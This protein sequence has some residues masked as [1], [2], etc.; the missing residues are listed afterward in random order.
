[1]TARRWTG[2]LLGVSALFPPVL[3]LFPALAL[4]QAPS[5]RDQG[6]FFYPLKLYT[7]DRLR[8]REL[9]LWNPLSG[10]GEPWLANLQSGVFYP[11]GI[12]FLLPGPALAGGLFLLF[13]FAVA[14]WGMWRFLREE[15][16]SEAGAAVGA[17]LF[18]ASGFAASLSAYWNHFGAYAWLPAAVALARSGLHRRRDRVGLAAVIGLQAMAGSPEISGATLLL[19]LLFSWLSRPAADGGYEAPSPR[20]TARAGAA[21]LLGLALA[22][23]AL[24]PFAQ[25]AA[26]SDRRIPLPVAERDAGAVEWAGLA[27]AAGAGRKGSGTTYLPSLAFGPLALIAVAAALLE[28][29]R[30]TLAW[31]LAAIAA[32][33]IVLSSAGP[34][35][36]VLRSVPPLDRVRYPAKALIPA[37][38]ALAA[39]A[40]LGVDALRFSSE[41][42]RRAFLAAGAAFAAAI[43]L[44]SPA[45]PPARLLE[46]AAIA[47][48]LAGAALPDGRG[49]RSAFFPAAAALCLAAGFAIAGGGLFR[50][51]PEAEIRRRPE[52]IAFLAGI[53]GRVLTPP[54]GALVPRVLT[55]S[56]YGASTLR[57]QREGLVGY[58]NLLEG[59]RTVRTAS[60]LATAAARRITDSIDGARDLQRTAGSASARV[61]W[62]SYLP[63]DMGSR[64]IGDFYRAPINPYRPRLSFVRG[65]TLERDPQRAWDR[66]ARGETDWSRN[67]FLE[68][69]PS[70][71]P[72]EGSGRGGFLLARMS[73]DRPEKI[74]AE[75]HADGAGILVLTDVAAPGWRAETDGKPVRILRADGVF[76]AVALSAGPHRVVFTYRPIAFYAG[77]ALS[78]V[79]LVWIL[80]LWRRGE[81]RRAGALL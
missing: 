80:A 54:M 76:R 73:E 19:V 64:R 56:D 23:W 12:F 16:V 35:G 20:R 70:P 42:R 60:P 69:E 68:E 74:A 33:G 53:S 78:V 8:A 15:A 71:A 32:A 3:W 21:I 58:T 45:P 14:V 30:R 25:L 52:P 81:P 7:A 2:A 66:R 44:L 57:R 36:A 39:L 41:A 46:A 50:F 13:H 38:F 11:P 63:Q 28:R 48:L 43:L 31:S 29:E 22:G 51:V 1:M 62:S 37:A 77:A 10:A 65:F 49:G 79:A 24:A 5:F 67:V 40:G 47:A 59:V 17:L 27:S 18:A 9:P 6:D 55:E 26:A 4:R 72:L 75:V 34:V 61:L